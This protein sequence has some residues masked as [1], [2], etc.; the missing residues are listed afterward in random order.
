MGWIRPYV[1]HGWYF[2]N[3]TFHYLIF[4]HTYSC[5]KTKEREVKYSSWKLNETIHC[6][7]TLWRNRTG[8]CRP[9]LSQSGVHLMSHH[10]VMA[11]SSSMVNLITVEIYL[12]WT[13]IL[14]TGRHLE[15]P[16]SLHDVNYCSWLKSF[17]HI[18]LFITSSSIEVEGRRCG[19]AGE[20]GQRQEG[21]ELEGIFANVA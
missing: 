6:L 17:S 5:W 2:A 16:L 9:I 14:G 7:K 3:L 20:T 15:V 13:S 4:F 12:V 11:G 19:V 1:A 21:S 10:I 8:F 18:Q